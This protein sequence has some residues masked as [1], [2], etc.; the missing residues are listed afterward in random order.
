MKKLK[1]KIDKIYKSKDQLKEKL[2]KGGFKFFDSSNES[3]IGIRKG[4]SIKP[5][6]CVIIFID[7]WIWQYRYLDT[8]CSDNYVTAEQ[9][10][11]QIVELLD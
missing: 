8:T 10:I 3:Y 6:E 2:D 9:F 1:E 4:D 11:D 7:G 5:P